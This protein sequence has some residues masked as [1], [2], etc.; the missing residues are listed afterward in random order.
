VRRTSAD[1]VRVDHALTTVNDAAT[2]KAIFAALP[3]AKD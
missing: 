2:V 3:K 1:D